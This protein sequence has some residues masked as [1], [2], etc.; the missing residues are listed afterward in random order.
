[1]KFIII[2]L[3][4]FSILGCQ[5]EVEETDEQVCAMDHENSNFTNLAIVFESQ[6]GDSWKEV[7]MSYCDA[8]TGQLHFNQPDNSIYF[9]SD[10]DNMTYLSSSLDYQLGIDDW[11]YTE[12]RPIEN[13]NDNEILILEKNDNDGLYRVYY[14]PDD[15]VLET[16]DV[17][18]VK[19]KYPSLTTNSRAKTAKELEQLYNTYLNL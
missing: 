6:L 19:Q 7:S 10:D 15:T 2:L 11:F 8:G 16:D 9:E 18:E 1:M 14:Y 5:D 3:L 12:N 4:L 13:E 17:N